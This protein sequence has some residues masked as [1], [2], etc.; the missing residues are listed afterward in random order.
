MR[1]ATFIAFLFA[2]SLAALPATAQAPTPSNGALFHPGGPGDWE[3]RWGVGLSVD[4]LPE[5]LVESE[6]QQLPRLTSTFRLGFPY[7]FS[8]DLNALVRVVD[9]ELKLG[10][11][12]G[13]RTGS[14]TWSLHDRFAAWAGWVVLEGFDTTGVGGSH[15]PGLAVGFDVDDSYVSVDLDVVFMSFQKVWFGEASVLRSDDHFA[16]FKV[17]VTVETPIG[18]GLLFY[19]A[20]VQKTE[21]DYQLWFAFS[22]NPFKLLST[23]LF[24]G[25]A[26]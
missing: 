11:L 7:G 19:G 4:V 1:R 26:F 24:A 6:V 25:Y 17:G 15:E 9:N 21:P 12:W 14:V 2:S 13:Y 5:R 10:L 18:H 16:G 8:A 23:R 22:D 3:W 20:L